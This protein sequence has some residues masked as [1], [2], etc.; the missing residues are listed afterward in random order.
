MWSALSGVAGLYLV[1]VGVESIDL[2]RLL[3]HGPLPAVS[4]SQEQRV[5]HSETKQSDTTQSEIKSLRQSLMG[6]QSDIGQLRGDLESRGEVPGVVASLT[7]I[8]ERMSAATGLAIMKREAPV[9]VQVPAPAAVA[10]VSP[11]AAPNSSQPNQIAAITPQAAALPQP[12]SGD[13]R[14]ITL[15][16]PALEQLLQPIETGSIGPAAKLAGQLPKAVPGAAKALA[17]PG[18]AT[19]VAAAI[20]TPAVATEPM[21]QDGAAPISFGPA[22]VKAAPRPFGVQLASGTTLDSIKLSW[23]LL[24][25]QHADALGKLNPRVTQTGTQASGQIYDLMAG[26]FKT[27]AEARKTCKALAARGTDCKVA[28]FSGEAF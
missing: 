10:V 5:A 21:P 7:A 2:P 11:E 19:P 17:V 13:L 18:S 16:P 1:Q 25:D 9:A 8:E 6:F 24:S 14:P 23:S 28:P 12:A 27:A 4:T 15:A 26:P 22:V 3:A 20:T